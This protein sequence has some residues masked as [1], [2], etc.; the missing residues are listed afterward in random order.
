MLYFNNGCYSPG[1][2]ESQLLNVSQMMRDYFNQDGKKR[3]KSQYNQMIKEMHD[4][5]NSIPAYYARCGAGLT[6]SNLKT[7]VSTG[8]SWTVTGKYQFYSALFHLVERTSAWDGESNLRIDY[9]SSYFDYV[10]L[11]SAFMTSK[12]I[13]DD[14]LKYSDNIESRL[15]QGM[16]F[17]CIAM[18]TGGKFYDLVEKELLDSSDEYFG[19]NYTH[20]AQE[21]LDVLKM[22]LKFKP[23][24]NHMEIFDGMAFDDFGS[25]LKQAKRKTVNDN[26]INY[27]LTKEIRA[28]RKPS[29]STE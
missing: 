11:P 18:L 2:R 28:N 13:R 17:E 4:C 16:F 10:S 6:K 5:L 8:N 12:W 29:W 27:G 1:F 14:G 7:K 3:V 23:H 24:Q 15:A 26:T 21:T 20:V 9:L 25:H 19:K 22:V